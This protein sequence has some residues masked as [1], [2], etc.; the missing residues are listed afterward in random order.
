MGINWLE[1][2]LARLSWPPCMVRER[3]AAQCVMLL[4]DSDTCVEARRGLLAWLKDQP[5]ET[6]S[7]YPLLILLRLQAEGNLDSL[8]PGEFCSAV[9]VPSILSHI[10]GLE[11][12]EVSSQPD[13]YDWYTA[14]AP[15][16]YS[17]EANFQKYK[18]H[19]VP[20][21]YTLYADNLDQRCAFTRQWS[22]ETEEV[23][24]RA[25]LER[26]ALNRYFFDHVERSQ[27]I[28]DTRYGSAVLSGFLRA[29]SWMV[30]TGH[31]SEEEACGLAL[32]ACPVDIGFWCVG[33]TPKP[34]WWLSL[35]SSESDVDLVVGQ[36]WEEVRQL[37]QENPVEGE[38]CVVGSARGRV[39]VR[40][41]V[42]YELEIQGVLQAVHSAEKPDP[43]V[44]KA[45]LD[46]LPLRHP[47][48]SCPSISGPM[49]LPDVDTYELSAGGWH[50][51]PITVSFTGSTSPRWQFYRFTKPPK[52]PASYLV[53]SQSDLVPQ[54][55]ELLVNAGGRYLGSWHTWHDG[56]TE[57]SHEVLPVGV[58]CYTLVDRSAV[59]DFAEANRCTYCWIATVSVYFRKK[60]YGPFEDYNETRVFGESRL[61]L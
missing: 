11:L 20:P 52:I 23:N 34:Q 39:L 4:A 1:L 31:A 24:R 2:L 37:W 50:I 30:H 15:K 46:D 42:V 7:I 18:T 17:P 47:L 57:K 5:Y 33:T 60:D 48:R 3:A 44:L 29:I 56:L 8:S 38:S 25:G 16:N 6:T 58:G 59:M 28:S 14:S 40:S 43:N 49:G 54:S 12:G 36:L 21:M 19:V 13:W 27:V 51:L 45:M 61:I 53:N 22:Y 32:K 41:D 9:P 10:L 26:V 35:E 55:Q